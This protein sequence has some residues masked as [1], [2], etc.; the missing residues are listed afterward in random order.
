MMEVFFS[1]PDY[2][3]Y[4]KLPVL[5]KSAEIP[6]PIST[7]EFENV[8]GEILTLIGSKGLRGFSISSFFP[9]KRYRWMDHDAPLADECIEFFK[10]HRMEPLRVVVASRERT[11]LN[12]LC[13]ISDFNLSEKPNED[14]TYTLDVKE[15]INPLEV[16]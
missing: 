1:V 11:Y 3:D 4:L 9:I 6:D 2:T 15:Y 5:L 10:A 13:T 16:R 12:M 8:N 14:V 7:T